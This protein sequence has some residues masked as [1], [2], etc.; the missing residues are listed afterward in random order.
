MKLNNTI[1]YLIGF[2]GVGKYTIAQEIVKKTGAKLVDNHLINN[3]LFSVV[4]QDGIT[5]LPKAIWAE[6]ATIRKTVYKTIRT[7][8]P[9]EFSFVFTN[10]LVDGDAGDRVIYRSVAA[11]AQARKARFVPIRILCSAQE[12]RKRRNTPDR[13]K[14]FKQIDLSKIEWLLKHHEVLHIKHPNLL[15]LDVSDFTAEQSAKKILAH[16]KDCYAD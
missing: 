14:R 9:P 15:T 7:L 3:P 2:S 16:V 10:L 5:P 8:S 4:K 13:R 12:M 6:V 11:L 1:L